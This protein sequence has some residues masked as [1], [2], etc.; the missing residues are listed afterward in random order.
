M[1]IPVFLPLTVLLLIAV[2]RSPSA[3]LF[4]WPPPVPS[5]EQLWH[6]QALTLLLGW[7]GLHAALYLLPLGKVRLLCLMCH[8]MYSVEV[9]HNT[10]N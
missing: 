7:V 8:C 2:S 5:T 1:C 10:D 4:Q 9:H 6:P 3:S